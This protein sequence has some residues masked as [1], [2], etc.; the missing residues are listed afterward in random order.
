[1]IQVPK[2][3]LKNPFCQEALRRR[4]YWEIVV[5]N[6]GEIDKKA[7]RVQLGQKAQPRAV[8]VHTAEECASIRKLCHDGIA[9]CTPRKRSGACLPL[10]IN[11]WCSQYHLKSAVKLVGAAVLAGRQIVFL[12]H[13]VAHIHPQPNLTLHPK[14]HASVAHAATPCPFNTA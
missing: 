9:T 3:R 11:F 5:A 7:Q 12:A 4:S 14:E 8:A 6:A 2:S 10:L 13:G 1:M